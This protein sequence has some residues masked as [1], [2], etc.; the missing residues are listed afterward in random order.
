MLLTDPSA[1][2]YLLIFTSEFLQGKTTVW[3][4]GLTLQLG[5]LW[6]FQSIVKWRDLTSQSWEK[7]RR[8]KAAA[9]RSP[10]VGVSAAGNSILVDS[11]GR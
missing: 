10:G 7:F 8:A 11:S 3:V 9:G 2:E 1:F 6:I 4:W 5:P